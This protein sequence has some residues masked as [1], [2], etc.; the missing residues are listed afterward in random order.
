MN[1]AIIRQLNAL[2]ARC[3]SLQA[4]LSAQRQKSDA[5]RQVHEYVSDA[6]NDLMR[7]L[8]AAEAW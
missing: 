5:H 3:E 2:T 6:K 7:A 1:K 8:R 4:K